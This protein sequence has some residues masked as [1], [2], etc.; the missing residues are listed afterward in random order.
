[1]TLLHFLNGLIQPYGY[2]GYLLSGL[3][4]VVAIGLALT[5]VDS[6]YWRPAQQATV[7]AA[8]KRLLHHH[9][10]AVDPSCN[11]L[12]MT[13]LTRGEQVIVYSE[14][15]G[16]WTYYDGVLLLVM[17]GSCCSRPGRTKKVCSNICAK[18]PFFAPAPESTA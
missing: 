5:E 14:R 17:T 8:V 12:V 3:L 18:F 10:F 2:Y 15:T 6:R 11:Y 7:K 13:C 9:G 4:V 1:M 16:H